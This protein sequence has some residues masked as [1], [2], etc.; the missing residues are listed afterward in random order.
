MLL[1]PLVSTLT[2]LAAA[3]VCCGLLPLLL[4]PSIRSLEEKPGRT[5]LLV[6]LCGLSVWAISIGLLF[7]AISSTTYLLL[8]TLMGLGSQLAAVGYLLMAAE[9]TGALEVDRRLLGAITAVLA[10]VQALSL[11]DPFHHLVWD[12]TVGPPL[13]EVSVGP[14]AVVTALLT[15]V[16]GFGALA[17][18]VVDTI[19]AS[20]VR[21]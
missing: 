11:T 10:I 7:V 15:F 3:Y 19:T 20:G 18:L 8:A 21:R 12:G 4:V 6:T 5:G 2:F 9:Y 17:L 1:T 16:V 13:T 14:V